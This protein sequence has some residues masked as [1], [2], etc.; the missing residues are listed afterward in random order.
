MK[1]L[2]LYILG[3]GLLVFV[4]YL[5]VRAM[6]RRQ[7]ISTRISLNKKDKNPYGAYVF[8]ESLRRFFPRAQHKINYSPPG[9]N[10]MF[11]DNKPDQLYVILQPEFRPSS[12][13]VDD[14]ITYIDRGNNVFIS[15]FSGN[16]EWY[17]FI[18]AFSKTHHFSYYP[19]G[20]FEGDT[21]Q[22][23]LAARYFTGA[24]AYAYPGISIEGYFTQTDD[25]ITDILGFGNDGQP[26]FIHL[27]KGAGNLYLHLSPIAFT[28]YFL[29]YKN[30]IAYFEKIF[31]RLPFETS[32]LIWDEY[33]KKDEPRKNNKGWLA[34]ILENNFFRAG[35]LT[36]LALMLL[37]T[38]TEMRRRQRV[39]PHLQKPSNDSL[40]FVKTM[41]LLY[42]ER[43]DHTNLAYKISTYF[44][45]H[46][47]SRYRIFSKD[48]NA[49][50][51]QEL[52]FKSGVNQFLV[53]Q[54][55]S[56]IRRISN[57]DAFSDTELIALQHNID[58][59]YNNE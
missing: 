48:L 34:A 36:V 46:V 14:L 57:G 3:F 7:R 41:G 6:P 24:P 29:L 44:L 47:R 4:L 27:K 35:I 16:E 23:Q 39:I 49:S 50:F 31:S 42:Y 56:Q 12:Y 52:H 15:T 9:N 37:F 58:E 5:V 13:D 33:F 25:S 22:A 26:N 43:G 28:N 20:A 40:D 10:K 19:Y 38:I 54:I 2:P 21:M 45:E 1:K 51:E 8:Y 32:L 18:K 11:G 53:K 59:F 17:R 30:N 55:V